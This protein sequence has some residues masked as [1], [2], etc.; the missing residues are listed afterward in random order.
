MAD[1]IKYLK[2]TFAKIFLRLDRLE[3][4]QDGGTSQPSKENHKPVITKPSGGK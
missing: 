3:E 1:L 4:M 2:A